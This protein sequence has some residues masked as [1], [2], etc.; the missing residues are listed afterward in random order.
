MVEMDEELDF[1]LDDEDY[2]NNLLYT[3]Q[4]L[5]NDTNDEINCVSDRQNKDTN[6][7]IIS[8]T[9]IETNDNPIQET[10]TKSDF[11]DKELIYEKNDNKFKNKDKSIEKQNKSSFELSSNKSNDSKRKHKKRSHLKE[12]KHKSKKNK[13]KELNSLVDPL[14]EQNSLKAKPYNQLISVP[15]KSSKKQSS[16]HSFV[17]KLSSSK[18]SSTELDIKEGKDI[19]NSEDSEKDWDDYDVDG[20]CEPCVVIIHRYSKSF[21][22]KAQKGKILFEETTD[23][24]DIGVEQLNESKNLSQEI[25]FSD[26]ECEQ[27]INDNQSSES[28][29][30]Q[31]RNKS[32]E[33]DCFELKLSESSSDEDI[34]KNNENQ[35]ITASEEVVQKETE[36]H[37]KQISARIIDF[38]S[39]DS[40]S[41]DE[42]QCL[43][44]PSNENKIKASN[45]KS[46]VGRIGSNC[47][48]SGKQNIMDSYPPKD[49][50]NS[51]GISKKVNKSNSKIDNS[52][53][54]K[55][56]KKKRTYLKKL[57]S[58]SVV[59]PDSHIDYNYNISTQLTNEEMQRLV[60]TYQENSS[61]IDHYKCDQCQFLTD[62]EIE[63][64]FHSTAHISNADN[65]IKQIAA[66][67]ECQSTQNQ[68]T[69]ETQMVFPSF[70]DQF[71]EPQDTPQT[72][73]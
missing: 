55:L 67:I 19:T 51:D 20:V 63:L 4:E 12:K 30:S 70:M 60:D 45:K 56:N 68:S 28:Q 66:Q 14:K 13:R 1:E 57:K 35:P 58:N 43:R 8:E 27:Q 32:N 16:E 71:P 52:L 65:Q 38:S 42:N 3:K 69:D 29:K 36:K 22:R 21:I 53:D 54:P 10:E 39:S 50:T 7:Q 72:G 15:E 25:N 47:D 41:N 49:N 62:N 26:N 61:K 6:N 44:D 17:Q 37:S 31:I 64:I 40:E 24:E 5:N 23:S 34:T 73:I 46:K 2:V 9:L 18:E 48:N 59:S 33:K 11:N